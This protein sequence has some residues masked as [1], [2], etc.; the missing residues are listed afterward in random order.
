MTTKT[1][2]EARRT[3]SAILDAAKRGE[4]TVVTRNGEP[5]AEVGPVGAGVTRSSV[6]FE[7]GKPE[8]VT[9]QVGTVCLRLERMD[10][11][12]WWLGLSESKRTLFHGFV[13]GGDLVISE[14]AGVG[15]E[16]T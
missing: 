1:S 5:V 15:E 10:D 16:G 2:H 13:Q 6:D 14:M 9:L 8:D 7:A 12:C 11:A 4:R 3:W